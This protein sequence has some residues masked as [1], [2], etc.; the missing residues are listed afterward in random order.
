MDDIQISL[1]SLKAV[2]RARLIEGITPQRMIGGAAAVLLVTFGIS[3]VMAWGPGSTADTGVGPAGNVPPSLS[4]T[5]A[6]SGMMC[7]ECGIVESTRVMAQKDDVVDNSA[8]EAG[9]QGGRYEMASTPA[10]VSEVTVRMSD[11]TSHLFTDANLTN[12]RTGERVILIKG[13]TSR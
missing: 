8:A 12:W 10:W 6:P 4:E 9:K 2:M 5:S 1:N 7:E 13:T 11:G 3:A